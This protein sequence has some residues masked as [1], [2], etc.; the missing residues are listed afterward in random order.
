MSEVAVNP[1]ELK[2]L[3]LYGPVIQLAEI[4]EQYL[5]LAYTDARKHAAKNALPFPTCRARDSERAPLLVSATD[6]A[7]FIDS[8]FN[9]AQSSWERSQP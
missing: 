2:L 9:D 1:T 8:M 4:C 5:G 7:R 3:A 6:L